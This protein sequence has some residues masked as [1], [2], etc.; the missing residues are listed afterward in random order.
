M[1]VNA[2][3]IALEYPPE[4]LFGKH[5]LADDLTGVLN[6]YLQQVIFGI[7]QFQVPS[8]PDYPALC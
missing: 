8:S 3:I 2:S 6:Q 7:G 5:A 4:P 1:H